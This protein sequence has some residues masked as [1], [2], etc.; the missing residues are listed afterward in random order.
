[1][2]LQASS[3][4]AITSSHHLCAQAADPMLPPTDLHDDVTVLRNEDKGKGKQYNDMDD[5]DESRFDLEQ[6][7]EMWKAWSLIE[8]TTETED[9]SI[10]EDKDHDEGV[11]VEVEDQGEIGEVGEVG[12]DDHT[13]AITQLERAMDRMAREAELIAAELYVTLLE[14]LYLHTD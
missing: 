5:I 10:I 1:M 9:D 8:D 11:V 14:F 4:L 13:D 12:E 6:E 3:R 2:A 7:G